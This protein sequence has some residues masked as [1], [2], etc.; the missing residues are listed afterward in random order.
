VVRAVEHH[1]A[2]LL[3]HGGH[4]VGARRMVVVVAEHREHRDVEVAHGVGEDR[5]LLG[6]AVR[7]EVAGQQ[8]QV[9]AA[10]QGAERRMGPLAVGVAAEMHVAGGRDADPALLLDACGAAGGVYRHPWWRVPTTRWP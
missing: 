9:D 3:E 2:R 10:G 8:D 1:D 4:L 7:G 5:G 6:L